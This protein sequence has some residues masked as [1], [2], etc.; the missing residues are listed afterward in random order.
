MF[1]N[2]LQLRSIDYFKH[3]FWILIESWNW[4][5]VC[6]KVASALESGGGFSQVLQSPQP[7]VASHDFFVTWQKKLTKIKNFQINHETC[8][9]VF[10]QTFHVRPKNCVCCNPLTSFY[11]EK[12]SIPL[13]FF[14][15]SN[16]QSTW[17]MHKAHIFENKNNPPPPQKKKKLIYD[18]LMLLVANLANTKCCKIL[19]KWLKPWYMGTHL[20]VLGNSYPMNTNLTG[21]RWFLENFA[22]LCLG[23]K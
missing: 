5:G 20:R 15:L 3:L 4:A 8:T 2:D 16:S 12:K 18:T 11:L 22:S 19:E 14:C 6:E 13:S 1:W 10:H 17:R 7:E 9:L 23:G 21:F